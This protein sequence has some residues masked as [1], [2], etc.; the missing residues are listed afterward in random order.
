MAL[1]VR[2]VLALLLPTANLPRLLLARARHR[3][4]KLAVLLSDEG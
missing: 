3:N 1:E 2:C 4:N